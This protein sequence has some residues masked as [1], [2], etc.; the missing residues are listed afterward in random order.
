MKKSDTSFYF[1]DYDFLFQN[2]VRYQAEILH[3][4]KFILW[5]HQEK[6][7]IFSVTHE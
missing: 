2:A 1:V 3:T 4:Y 5:L 7:V 6:F